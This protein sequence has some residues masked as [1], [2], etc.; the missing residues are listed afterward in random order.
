MC[1]CVCVW[2]VCVLTLGVCECV[3]MCVRVYVCV[4]KCVC[5]CV[6]LIVCVCLIVCM[7]VPESDHP[8]EHLWGKSWMDETLLGLDFRISPQSFF[9]VC[10]IVCV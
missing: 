2:S 9:Q 3:S 4:S 7:D 5:V 10:L 6:R 1:V 8:V